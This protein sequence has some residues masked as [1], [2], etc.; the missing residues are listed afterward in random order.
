MYWAIFVTFTVAR[1]CLANWQPLY[2][3]T[4]ASFDDA[5]LMSHAQTIAQ[6]DWLGDYQSVTLIK[7][8][9]FPVL[10]TI[11]WMTHISYQAMFAL[12]IAAGAGL[13]SCALKRLV[14]SR[15]IRLC[16]YGAMLYMPSQTEP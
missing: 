7:N 14:P 13:F 1:L 9:A 10:A 2:I 3:N 15:W 12:L 16:V 5:L 11:P 8:P 4:L 6:G